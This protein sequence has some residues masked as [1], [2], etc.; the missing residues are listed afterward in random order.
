MFMQSIETVKTT[1]TTISGSQ[2][3]KWLLV[4][5]EPLQG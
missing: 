1:A 3:L 2:N 4:L 5:S